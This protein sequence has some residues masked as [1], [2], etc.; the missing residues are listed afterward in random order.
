MFR[1]PLRSP[2]RRHVLV[3]VALACCVA[4]DA[5]EDPLGVV[6]DDDPAPALAPRF[7]LPSGAAIDVMTAAAAPAEL[8][9]E[10]ILP[11]SVGFDEERHAAVVA[12]L[13]GVVAE[14]DARLGDQ[15]AAGELLVVLQSPELARAR[16]AYVA[17]SQRVRLARAAY[18]R[19]ERLWKKRITPEE[20]YLLAE[21]E[22]EVRELERA[23]AG[24]ELRALGVTAA[25]LATLATGETSP[26]ETGADELAAGA[27]DLTRFERR[28]PIAGVV[29]S[30]AAVLGEAVHGDRTLFEVADLSRV[31][32]D[33][34]VPAS[35]LADLGVGTSVTV[36]SDDLA[37][38]TDAEISYLD[39]RVDAETQTALARVVLANEDG[40][41]R[42]GLWVTVRARVD[43]HDAEVAVPAAALHRIG[44]AAGGAVVFVAL[45]DGGWEAREVRLGREDARHA[46][47][48]S[49]LRPGEEVAVSEGLILKSV[50][51][52]QGGLGE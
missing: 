37:R 19:E 3:A 51:L 48:V 18:E 12:R 1:P 22:R 50:W 26:R 16:A 4:C 47:V 41:W 34:R 32:I 52:G 21:H 33:L 23:T 9:R 14:I 7:R 29:V 10:L 40:A 25:E 28:A 45:P 46:E 2:A 35:D 11:G 15:V 43:R 38:T 31:W 5:R 20:S 27:R 44:D 30:R 39:P 49:G 36:V 42:P 6:A 24:Q 13:D 17:A 8:A